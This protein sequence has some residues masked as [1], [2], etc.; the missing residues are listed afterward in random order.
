[1]KRSG[2]TSAMNRGRSIDKTLTRSTV[3]ARVGAMGG[4]PFF[5]SPS[6]GGR[7]KVKF[8]RQ[9]GIFRDEHIYSRIPINIFPRSPVGEVH[10]GVR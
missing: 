6:T 5:L 4:H 9:H 3:K 7:V 8:E 10:V 2:S 1:V